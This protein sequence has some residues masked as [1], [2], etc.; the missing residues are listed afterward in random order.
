MLWLLGV[1]IDRT[2]T[3]GGVDICAQLFI[4]RRRVNVFIYFNPL[5]AND[6]KI[7]QK[8]TCVNDE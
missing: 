6:G 8:F 7:R 5:Y 4:D 2:L 3:S 1:V